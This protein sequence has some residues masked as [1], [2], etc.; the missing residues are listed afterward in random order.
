MAC[1]LLMLLG[2]VAFAQ[3]AGQNHGTAQATGPD[4]SAAADPQSRRAALRAVLKT[5]PDAAAKG[6]PMVRPER[7]FSEKERAD[8]RQQLRQQLAGAP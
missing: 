1:S 4:V 5:Q 3:T 8:L 6:V 2:A 7:Q